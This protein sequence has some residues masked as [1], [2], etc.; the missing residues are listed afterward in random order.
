MLCGSLLYG[1]PNC[2]PKLLA[3]CETVLQG[4]PRGSLLLALYT[5]RTA[6]STTSALLLIVVVRLSASTHVHLVRIVG[7]HWVDVRNG[8]DLHALVVLLPFGNIQCWRQEA[9]D[10]LLDL[11]RKALGELDGEVQEQVPMDEGV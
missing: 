5:A 1:T 2:G 6:H 9:L 11:G 3:L 10:L 4:M 8:V 7:L